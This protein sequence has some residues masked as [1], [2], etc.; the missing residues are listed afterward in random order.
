LAA[1]FARDFRAARAGF[2]AAAALRPD[3]RAAPLM[4]ARAARLQAD[5][6]GPDWD[7]V[8]VATTK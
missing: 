1:Y 5:P 6:L 7:G 2:R 8:Y 3:D 4:A